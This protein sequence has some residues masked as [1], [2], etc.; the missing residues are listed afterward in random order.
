[1]FNQDF[2]IFQQYAS[3]PQEQKPI[4]P[5]PAAHFFR[6]L[7]TSSPVTIAEN[8]VEDSSEEIS[9]ESE[10]GGESLSTEDASDASDSDESS[11]EEQ[12]NYGPRL[13]VLTL[14]PQNRS[15][16]A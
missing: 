16:F 15:S 13:A 8:L 5:T 9:D 12:S 3:F 14:S 6:P 11:S 1:M 7:S 10:T 2:P 4:E